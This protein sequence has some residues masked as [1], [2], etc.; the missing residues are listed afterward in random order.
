MQNR[1][2]PVSLVANNFFS[3]EYTMAGAAPEGPPLWR[4]SSPHPEKGRSDQSILTTSHCSNSMTLPNPRLQ[5]AEAT[6][7]PFDQQLLKALEDEIKADPYR[8][9]NRQRS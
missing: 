7:P 4:S 5:K 6:L 2:W 3:E 1:K 9:N 8:A